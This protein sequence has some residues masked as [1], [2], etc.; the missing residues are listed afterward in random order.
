VLAFVGTSGFSY[1]PWKGPF[2][3]ADLPGTR[4]LGYYAGKLHSV[5]INNTFYRM[6]KAETL[7]GWREQVPPGFR[8]AIKAPQRITH[9]KRLKE[10][11]EPVRILYAV[12]AELGDRLGPILYQ[13][14][15]NL[16][17]DVP[18]LADFLALLPRGG[19]TAFEFRHPSWFSDDV[20]QLMRE[21]G[22][23]LC[24]AETDEVSPPGIST[25]PWGYLR[26][27]RT[28]YSDAQLSDWAEAIRSRPWEECYVF[29][30]HEDGAKGPAFAQRLMEQIRN[31]G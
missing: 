3:P 11:D 31:A 2:Y 13:L 8:F 4:M 19:R 27:R 15:P 14:P 30:K 20:Y 25:A 26:L 17:K 23:A 24:L 28:E 21:R 29:F 6:P 5:E 7:A 16:K 22:I 18:R 10:A 1:A 12:A 9:V